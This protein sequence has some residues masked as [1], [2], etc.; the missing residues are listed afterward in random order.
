MTSHSKCAPLSVELRVRVRNSDDIQR[1]KT[2]QR[3][4]KKEVIAK[5]KNYGL[6]LFSLSSPSY[7]ENY[8][9]TQSRGRPIECSLQCDG[10]EYF[11]LPLQQK[12][13]TNLS[14]C[15]RALKFINR[16]LI[17]TL[18]RG[19]SAAALVHPRTFSKYGYN[20]VSLLGADRW[21]DLPSK[22]R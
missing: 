15:D 21:N 3:P 16:S 7:Y 18:S 13:L 9:S 6:P 4:A 19:Q 17:R 22:W 5:I 12:T 11:R 8:L 20:S 1:K 14:Q 10:G 2:V